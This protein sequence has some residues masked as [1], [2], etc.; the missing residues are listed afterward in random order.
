MVYLG[1]VEHTQVVKHSKAHDMAITENSLISDFASRIQFLELPQ[2]VA[3]ICIAAVLNSVRHGF[4]AVHAREADAGLRQGRLLSGPSGSA[5]AIGSETKMSVMGAAFANAETLNARAELQQENDLA[6]TMAPYLLPGLLAVA[7]KDGVSGYRVMRAIVVAYEIAHRF[8]RAQLQISSDC[9]HEVERASDS[10]RGSLALAAVAGIA[11]SKR[12]SRRYISN[13]LNVAQS[14]PST[15]LCHRWSNSHGDADRRSQVAGGV[16]LHALN[17]VDLAE[18]GRRI[19]LP[20]SGSRSSRHALTQ[21]FTGFDSERLSGLGHEWALL[22]GDELPRWR[23]PSEFKAFQSCLADWHADPGSSTYVQAIATTLTES[24]L[25]RTTPPSRQSG[26]SR[27]RWD[28]IEIANEIWAGRAGPTFPPSA[29]NSSAAARHR[30][31]EAIS[32]F[33]DTLGPLIGSSTT[34]AIADSIL[35]L[36]RSRDLRKMFSLIRSGRCA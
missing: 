36:E 20:R 14:T 30:L 13:S 3:N 21:S 26:A 7:E 19:G 1:T 22:S 34:R 5:S 32:R 10:Q 25:P 24:R 17:A 9:G 35:K 23:A 11:V 6:S 12:F 33:V 28:Q 18:E 15:G 8:H 27:R 2:S 29:I 4:S 16:A 31:D